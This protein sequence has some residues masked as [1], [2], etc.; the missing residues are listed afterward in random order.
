[1]KFPQIF[2]GFALILMQ[3]C[4]C[5]ETAIKEDQKIHPDTSVPSS[6]YHQKEGSTPKKSYPKPSNKKKD[7]ILEIRKKSRDLDTLIP[8]VA[9]LR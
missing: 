8:Q 9:L 3:L 6:E 1:M 7:S 2:I 5:R 4:S